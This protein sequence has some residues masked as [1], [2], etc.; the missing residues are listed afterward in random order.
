MKTIN[1]FHISSFPFNSGGIDTWLYNFLLRYDEQYEINLICPTCIHEN[2]EQLFNIKPFKN[3]KIIYIHESKSSFLFS[4]IKRFYLYD[5]NLKNISSIKKA[6]I[7]IALS[8]YPVGFVVKWL[9]FRK[10]INGK[11]IMSVRGC[12]ARDMIDLNE[13]PF[14]KKIFFLLEKYSMNLYDILISNGDDTKNYLEKNFNLA[15]FVIPNS[16]AIKKLHKKNTLPP[17]AE[18]KKKY[19]IISH[20]GTLRKIK[21][22]SKLIEAISIVQKNYPGKI[23]L[24]LAGKGNIQY[25]RDYAEKIDAHVTFLDELKNY[26]VDCLL[27][28]S[29]V[30]VNIS[31]GCGVSN[32]LLEAL[33]HGCKVV[34][35]DRD[36]FNQVI[37][38]NN[39]GYLA[40]DQDIDSLA[41]TIIYA[42]HDE[43]IKKDHIINSIKRYD[44]VNVF[45]KWDEILK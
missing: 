7:N 25:Y 43:T 18:L 37:I 44:C 38:N 12:V 24:V 13:S 15:S 3:T 39:N 19:K 17:I 28:L 30:V 20:I 35:F 1:I 36:T 22:I 34:A 32:S 31:Y 8:T 11:L 27:E 14:T 5:K 4:L 16:I 10:I 26:E 41:K 29:D 6:Y 9:K 40:T 23:L 33:A 45:K 2:K 42:I 21:N